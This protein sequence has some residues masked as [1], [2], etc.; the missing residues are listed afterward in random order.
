MPNVAVN[1]VTVN[2]KERFFVIKQSY[3][4]SGLGFEVCE[5]RTKALLAWLG[6]GGERLPR[7][8]TLAAYSFYERLTMDA[9]A[10]H[11]RTG[12]RC[13]VE[14]CPQLVGREGKRVEVVDKYG[15]KR[16]FYV[17]KSTGWMPVHLEIATRRSSGGGAVSGAPF[18]SV[19][20]VGQ[21]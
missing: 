3:G 12:R 2:R 20:V 11:T 16:R 4:Y 14:L 13:E 9:S 6:A 21:R 5:Q 7:K 8:G 10:A 1:N 15:E 18:K 17:G 19:T